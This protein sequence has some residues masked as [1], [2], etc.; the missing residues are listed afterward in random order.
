MS[1]LYWDSNSTV[2]GKKAMFELGCML[3]RIGICLLDH[4]TL[5]LTNS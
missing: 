1:A 5:D 4:E 3:E 2:K